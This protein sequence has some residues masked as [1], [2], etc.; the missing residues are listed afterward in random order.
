MKIIVAESEKIELWHQLNTSSTPK[1]MLIKKMGISDRKLRA[2][3]SAINP[4]E[5]HDWLVLTDTSE[6]GYWKGLKGTDPKDA[7]RNYYEEES[8]AMNTMR[9]VNA[10]KRKIARIYGAEALDPSVKLQGSL[11]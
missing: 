10:M 4:D 2:I 6:G 3:A 7:V 8:R 9:K 5:Q 1:E 11:F